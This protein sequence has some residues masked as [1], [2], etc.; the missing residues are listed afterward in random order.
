MDHTPVAQWKSS[1]TPVRNSPCSFGSF[2]RPATARS[3]LEAAPKVR[4][5]GR[6][7]S[8]L[9]E[10][11]KVLRQ[12]KDE[13]RLRA[14]TSDPSLLR[15]PMYQLSECVAGR[16]KRTSRDTQ[17]RL[18]QRAHD[19]EQR[20]VDESHA[21]RQ[22][23]RNANRPVDVNR[24]DRLLGLTIAAKAADTRARATMRI[25]LSP[26]FSNTRTTKSE[27]DR[28]HRLMTV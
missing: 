22:I 28:L 16:G 13:E 8:L 6:H 12:I 25:H 15:T 19:R 20:W 17:L 2:R 14:A 10:E 3:S 21:V 9:K 18:A 26:R 11:E 1:A 27:I 5:I 23:Y 24:A 7:L 4:S